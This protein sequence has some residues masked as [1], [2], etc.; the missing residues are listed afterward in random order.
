MRADMVVVVTPSAERLA[1][2]DEAVEDLFLKEFVAQLYLK[3]SMQAF[4]VGLPLR[5][6]AGLACLLLEQSRNSN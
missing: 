5:F 3:L 2:V 4:C 6:N 1:Y